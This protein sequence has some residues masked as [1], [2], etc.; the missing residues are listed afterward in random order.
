MHLL[1]SSVP[2]IDGPATIK[3][4]G[5]AYSGKNINHWVPGL[6]TAHKRV[7]ICTMAEAAAVHWHV[8]D[9][10]ALTAMAPREALAPRAG[11]ESGC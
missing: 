8:M 7:L 1:F 11:F 9:Q 10:E 4:G 6:F 3:Q 5:D 2:L